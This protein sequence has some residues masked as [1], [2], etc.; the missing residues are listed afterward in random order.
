MTEAEKI[1]LM[2]TGAAK[3]VSCM[4]EE[5]RR[6]FDNIYSEHYDLYYR[7]VEKKSK[8]FAVADCGLISLAMFFKTISVEEKSAL[9]EE[10]KYRELNNANR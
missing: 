1:N 4:S 2:H 3:V 8:D 9:L 7:E 10:F 5:Q 6:V